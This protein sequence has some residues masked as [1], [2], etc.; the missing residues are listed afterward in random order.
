MAHGI[1]CMGVEKRLL[2]IVL[3][4]NYAEESFFTFKSL[5]IYT[6][7]LID[8]RLLTYTFWYNKYSA[9]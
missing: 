8:K 5:L 2:G 9:N 6:L 1:E 3:K 7:L 4:N